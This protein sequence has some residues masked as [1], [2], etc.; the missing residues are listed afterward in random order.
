M[1]D[2]HIVRMFRCCLVIASSVA[3]ICRM[4]WSHDICIDANQGVWSS[5]QVPW[6]GLSIPTTTTSTLTSQSRYATMTRGIHSSKQN[7][8]FGPFKADL[9]DRYKLSIWAWWSDEWSVCWHN[10]QTEPDNALHVCLASHTIPKWFMATLMATTVDC[11][12]SSTAESSTQANRI[13]G[14]RERMLIYCFLFGVGLPVS[15]WWCDCLIS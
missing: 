8:N 5:V 11:F 9:L 14:Q 7:Q 4:L 13:H 15:W 12:R 10:P 3:G 6:P 1:L 2:V